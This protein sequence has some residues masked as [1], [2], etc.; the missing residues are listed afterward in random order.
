MKTRTIVSRCN[1]FRDTFGNDLSERGHLKTKRDCLEAL[2]GHR[3]WLENA[4]GDEMH[5]IDDFIHELGIEW[6]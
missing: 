5:R 4:V 3:N 6:E 2:R 1:N